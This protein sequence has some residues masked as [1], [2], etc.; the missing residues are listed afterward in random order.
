MKLAILEIVLVVA[1]ARD[2]EEFS[3]RLVSVL[4]GSNQAAV[5]FIKENCPTLET[6]KTYSII[7]E[8]IYH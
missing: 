2:C 4:K 5:E 1:Q 6:A 8:H 3:K 7:Q